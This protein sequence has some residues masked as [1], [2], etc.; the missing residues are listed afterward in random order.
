MARLPGS[1]RGD[2]FHQARLVLA[3]SAFPHKSRQLPLAPSRDASG[4]GPRI[5]GDSLRISG[6]SP[7]LLQAPSCCPRRRWIVPADAAASARRAPCGR[8]RCCLHVAGEEDGI[9]GAG[10]EDGVRG[11]ALD[12]D[13]CP[14]APYSSSPSSCPSFSAALD[15]THLSCLDLA[16]SD[17][18]FCARMKEE[19]GRQVLWAV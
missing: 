7:P 2:R 19:P 9:R 13:Y 8:A 11:G 3:V 15:F 17:V 18:G 6:V 10:E 14:A 12:A 16:C 5:F 4:G 1:E